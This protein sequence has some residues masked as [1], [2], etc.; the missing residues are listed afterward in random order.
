MSVSKARTISLP[1]GCPKGWQRREPVLDEGYDDKF[2]DALSPCM[3]HGSIIDLAIFHDQ[4]RVLRRVD[5]LFDSGWIVRARFDRSG[6]HAF[7]EEFAPPVTFRLTLPKTDA[8][9]VTS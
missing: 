2:E 4:R 9:E 7:I 5:A 6:D 8:D 1:K 3:A